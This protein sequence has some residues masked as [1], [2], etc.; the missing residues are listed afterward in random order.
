MHVSLAEYGG[1]NDDSE[2]GEAG[3]QV[4]H[5]EYPNQIRRKGHTAMKIFECI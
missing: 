2:E 5:I 4:L 1:T 3:A